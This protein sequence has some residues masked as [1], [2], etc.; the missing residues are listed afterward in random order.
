MKTKSFRIILSCMMVVVLLVIAACGS[1]NNTNTEPEAAAANTA[2]AP[3]ANA[4]NTAGSEPAATAVDPDAELA[5]MKGQVL[6]MGP[7]GEEPIP[8]S[9]LEVTDEDIAKLK[10]MNVTAALS[11]HY[12]GNDWSNA[13]VK[14]IQ[15][16]AARLGIE[17]IA[18]TDA[19]FKPDKQTADIETIMAKKPDI[20]FIVPSDPVALAPVYKKAAAAGIKIISIGQPSKDGKPG[21]DYVTVVGTDDVGNGIITA[22][23]IARELGGEGKIGII[24]HQADF[25]VTR[26]RYEGFKKTIEEMYPNIEIVVEQGVAGPDFTGD[27]EKAASAFLMRHP[28]LDAIW[29]P[30]DVPAEGIIVA[31][32]NAGRDDLVI[33]TM[34][35]G[36]N[37]AI[38]MAKGGMIKGIGATLVY[39][40]GIAEVRAGALSMLGKE[41]P[42][43]VQAHGL[44]VDKS[45]VL[46]AWTQVYGTEPPQELVNA[47]K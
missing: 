18:V 35:L 14:G 9:V 42:V 43:F 37:V 15:D 38:D 4:E 47:A 27:A 39:D 16:E 11:L 2:E 40:L 19:N 44:A 32:R 36:K 17:V 5:K 10:E 25:S 31:A 6:S 45:N 41:V 33:A 46:E 20:L 30:W 29:G 23:Q 13:Q 22:H 1:S 8:I 7:Y 28:D 26:N 24:F 3:Q 21:E 12:G 34:D